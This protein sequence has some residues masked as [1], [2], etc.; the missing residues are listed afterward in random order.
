MVLPALASCASRLALASVAW[1]PQSPAPAPSVP[2]AR[3]AKEYEFPTAAAIGEARLIEVRMSQVI[4]AR[5]G[6]LHRSESATHH[7]EVTTRMVDTLLDPATQPKD[8]EWIGRRRYL[9]YQTTQDGV[10]TDP[11]LTGREFE[12]RADK[13]QK[14]AV[15][16]REDASVGAPALQIVTETAATFGLGTGI[17]LPAASRVG[18]EFDV[19]FHDLLPWCLT[20]DG[21]FTKAEAHL[22]LDSVDE[23]SGLARFQGSVHLEETVAYTAKQTGGRAG[24]EG[25]VSHDGDVAIEYD[26]I[27]RRIARIEVRIRA[28]VAGH[29]TAAEVAQING[30]GGCDVTITCT[31]GAPVEAALGEPLQFRDVPREVAEEGI[32]LSLPSHYFAVPRERSGKSTFRSKSPITNWTATIDVE[33]LKDTPELW[34]AMGRQ[35]WSE[36]RRIVSRRGTALRESSLAVGRKDACAF[37]FSR[38]GQRGLEIVFTPAQGHFILV[39]CTASDSG[40]PD[41]SKEWTAFVQSLK[42]K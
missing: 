9:T 41:R 27:A 22:R 1:V 32:V 38:D 14:V 31:T 23:K 40:W 21:K 10:V 34:E 25:T 17:R 29:T 36:V 15:H 12:I 7:I 37:E 13:D 20:S 35:N 28:T 24:M 30:T 3:S 42:K 2:A 6:A 39:T 4:V 26:V 19:P 8:R 5:I 16:P 11:E 18:E 33:R